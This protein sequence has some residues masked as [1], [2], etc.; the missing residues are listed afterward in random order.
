MIVAFLVQQSHMMYILCTVQVYAW[1]ITVICL[2]KDL[3]K[4]AHII[5]KFIKIAT[6]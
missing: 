1:V 3:N 2:E 5:Q 4:R 6:Q